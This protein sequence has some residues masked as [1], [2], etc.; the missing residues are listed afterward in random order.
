MK[1]IL[2]SGCNGKMGRVLQ[3]MIA[4]DSSLEIVAGIDR[5]VSSQNDF[6]V[7]QTP[8]AVTKKA[9]IVID[10]SHY[11]NVPALINYCVEQELPA[12]IATTGLEAPTIALL[13]NAAKTI[14]IFYSANMSI[15]INVLIQALQTITPVLEADFD[16]EIIEKHHN[17]K[18]DAPSGTALL[19]ADSINEV[20]QEKKS[21]LFGRSGNDLENKRT[22]MGIHAVRG[23]TIP[24]EHTVIFAGNDEII[25]FKHTALSRDIF[26]NGALKAALFLLPQK[27]GFYSMKNL[28][29]RSGE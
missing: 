7:F 29:E 3:E 24:G 28:V 19:L 22:E 21:Y 4:K 20:C 15:G 16:I 8:E 12:V 25:E 9:D 27:P 14:P 5:S 1:R 6:P 13:E 10:F 18:K 23:G 2:L 26:A 11:S 17:Q